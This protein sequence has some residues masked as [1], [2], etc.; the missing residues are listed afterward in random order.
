M[1]SVQVGL[2]LWRRLTRCAC[3]SRGHWPS[4]DC[5][6]D[7]RHGQLP[8]DPR[9]PEVHRRRRQP[10]DELTYEERHSLRSSHIIQWYIRMVHARQRDSPCRPVTPRGLYS[11]QPRAQMA[12][13]SIRAPSGRHQTPPRSHP[14]C[15]HPSPPRHPRPVAG[16]SQAEKSMRWVPACAGVMIGT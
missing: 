6:A 2:A 11:R 1:N 9:D 16:E 8:R 13:L 15:R 5:R 7:R 4:G 12:S 3:G 14:R 10:G